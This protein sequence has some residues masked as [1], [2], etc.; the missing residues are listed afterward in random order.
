MAL[1][2]HQRHSILC[3]EHGGESI[4]DVLDANILA[5]M[6]LQRKTIL[7]IV[8]YSARET[9]SMTSLLNVFQY[10]YWKSARLICFGESRQRLCLLFFLLS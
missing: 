1:E 10:S 2:M 6:P 3:K 7:L 4:K 5:S 8:E 9:L